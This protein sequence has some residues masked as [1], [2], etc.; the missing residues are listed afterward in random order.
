MCDVCFR[1][2]F[3]L[4]GDQCM[5]VQVGDRLGLFFDTAVPPVYYGQSGSEFSDRPDPNNPPLSALPQVGKTIPFVDS[6]TVKFVATGFVLVS[7]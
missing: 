2:Q 6:L 3:Y 5:H 7:K 1:A 4:L